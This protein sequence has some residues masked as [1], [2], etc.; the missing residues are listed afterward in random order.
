MASL[1]LRFPTQ[2]SLNFLKCPIYPSYH[3][4]CVTLG[5]AEPQALLKDRVLST[6]LAKTHHGACHMASVQGYATNE[7]PDARW[8]LGTKHSALAFWARSSTTDTSGSLQEHTLH[9]HFIL[10]QKKLR[11]AQ[12]GCIALG[13]GL[14]WPLPPYIEGFHCAMEGKPLKKTVWVPEWSHKTPIYAMRCRDLV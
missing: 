2:I 1:D 4:S 14:W 6:C 13:K 10:H 5:V 11:L 12:T 7:W 3:F 8:P 9:T